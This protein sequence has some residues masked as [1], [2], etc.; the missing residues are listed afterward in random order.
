VLELSLPDGIVNPRRCNCSICRRKG[1][2]AASVPLSGLRIVKGQE[3]LR[4]YQ[5]NTRTA[6]H[7]FC[8]VCGIYT[9]HQRRSNPDQYGYNVGCL[10]GVDPNDIANVPTSD[11]VNHSSD[12]LNS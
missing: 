10:E 2:V 4:L 7:Y 3:T 6:K 5:F 12:R 1:A 8:S 9:H 11:G